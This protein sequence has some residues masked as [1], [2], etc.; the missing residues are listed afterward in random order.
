MPYSELSE[1]MGSEIRKSKLRDLGSDGYDYDLFYQDGTTVHMLNDKVYSIEVSSNKYQTPRGLRV[2][3][4]K[5]R[6]IELYNYPAYQSGTEWNYS[7]EGDYIL[8]SIIYE[9]DKVIKININLVM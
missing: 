2:G 3:D 8:F 4:T 6:V 7:T 1:V 9:D 5:E